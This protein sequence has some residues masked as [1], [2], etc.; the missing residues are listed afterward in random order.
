MTRLGNLVPNAQRRIL[1]ALSARDVRA[2]KAA[3][4]RD[5]LRAARNVQ[6]QRR[7]LGRATVQ[8]AARSLVAVLRQGMAMVSRHV[9]GTGSQ[10]S[11]RPRVEALVPGREMR[12]RDLVGR[13][14][15]FRVPGQGERR[16]S[17]RDTYARAVR[18]PGSKGHV[19]VVASAERP[20]RLEVLLVRDEVVPIFDGMAP[21][22]ALGRA[23]AYAE[24]DGRVAALGR[25]HAAKGWHIVVFDPEA[26]HIRAYFRGMPT[27][28]VRSQY[29]DDD[30][31]EFPATSYVAHVVGEALRDAMRGKRLYAISVPAH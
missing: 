19:V 2:A 11:V 26:R 5:L 16:A 25:T 20:T 13:W 30:V 6:E 1:G 18:L 8:A 15:L 9:R 27:R 24:L 17:Y 10:A 12:M 28:Y 4:S 7:R 21:F 3:G 22:G 23:L 14:T 31:A 29:A